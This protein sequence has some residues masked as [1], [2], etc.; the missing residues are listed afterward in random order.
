VALREIKKYL[1]SI[2][3]LIRKL[4]FSRLVRELTQDV[5]LQDKSYRF[6]ASAIDALQEATE[7]F[8]VGYLEGL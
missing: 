8:I 5:A 3:L 4:P 1:K 2:D 6:Q 7:A